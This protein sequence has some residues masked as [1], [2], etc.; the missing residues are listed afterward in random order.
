MTRLGAL[1]ALLIAALGS[2][3]AAFADPRVQQITVASS[4]V[5][6]Q[7][8]LPTP[9]ELAPYDAAGTARVAGRFNLVLRG[10]R[11]RL[12]Y[13]DRTVYLLP[14]VQWSYVWAFTYARSV[15][16]EGTRVLPFATWTSKYMRTTV[17][18]AHGN[19]AF[20]NVPPGKYV[21][22]AYVTSDVYTAHSYTTDD[23]ELKM[24]EVQSPL[25]QEGNYTYDREFVTEHHYTQHVSS[26]T[27]SVYAV[28]EA[29]VT[30]RP[31]DATTEVP[32]Q[33]AGSFYE[34]ECNQR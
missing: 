7:F 11:A 4:M 18:D 10:T 1:A 29:V 34:G 13:G 27:C 15:S 8:A 9:T 12:E 16:Q 23:P 19:F 21:L 2:S 28:L 14:A 30:V 6:P 33:I 25:D 26:S 31:G 24:E 32:V 20:D 17:T 3:D 5:D 22:A